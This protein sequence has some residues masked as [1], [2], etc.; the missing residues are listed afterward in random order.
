MTTKTVKELAEHVGGV[1]HGDQTVP[2]TGAAT[3]NEAGEG[4]ISF[5]ANLKYEK[6][7]QTSRASA[8]IVSEEADLPDR[9]LIRC[10]DPYYA[11]MQVVVLLYGHREHEKVGISP[12]ASVAANAAIGRD[13]D[14]HD[15]A[16]VLHDVQI[17]DNTCIYSNCTIGPGTKIGRDCVLY[18]NVTIYDGC[19]IGD[20]VTI[21]SGTVVGQ[22]GFGYATHDGVHH[23]IP[24]VG[25][26]VIEDDVEIGANC[27][28]DRGT[29]GD[30]II[31]RG[32]KLS[33]LIAIGHNT[34]IGPYS[35]LVAQV[36][37]AGSVQVGHHC[38]FGGQV[39]VVGHIKIGDQVKI[40]AQAGVINDVPDKLSVVGSPAWPI[41]QAKR[42]LTL[43]K[44]LP[45]FRK[46]LRELDKSLRRLIQDG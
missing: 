17:G 15:F 25:G 7:V 24:Q 13:V 5:L 23:K 2:I 34:K 36:G 31:G 21:H 14:I 46:K 33:N 32:S 45:E 11:F 43:L 29:L 19:C 1:V 42:S 8:I 10:R 26:V 22:D 28:I 30:T 38:V 16:V 12:R 39:G 6:E 9:V 4:D 18:P 35:L 37:I 40:G 44:E 20:R 41:T 3:L 27:A